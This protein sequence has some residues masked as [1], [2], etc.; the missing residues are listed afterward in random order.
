MWLTNCKVVDVESGGLMGDAAIEVESGIIRRIGAPP[1]QAENVIDLGGSYVVPGLVTCHAHLGQVY[2]FEAT[3]TT[4]SPAR[5]ALR[6]LKR[7]RDSLLAGVTTLRCVS[8]MHAVDIYLRDA[9]VAG[10]V[11]IPRLLAGGRS[12]TISGGHG[13]HFGS[14]VVADGEDAFLAAARQEIAIGADHLKIF[15]TGGIA[16]S[17]ENLDEPEMTPA[18]IRAVVT[19]ARQAKKYVVAHAAASKP[20]MEALSAGVRSFE[21]AYSLD[22]ATAQALAAA[23]VFLG[24]TLSV[25]RLPDFMR[26]TGFTEWQIAHALSVGPRHLESIRNAVEAGVT[27]VNSTDYPPGASINGTSVVVNELQ[28]MVEAGLS[29][30][31]ALRASTING[32]RLCNVDD[33]TGSICTGKSADLL[34]I[35]GD[36]SQ[37]VNAMK[38]L[39]LVMAAGRIVSSTL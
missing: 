18:E 32:A 29:P 33:I 24:P 26:E 5:T 39:R 15:I 2:P 10:W 23:D 25:T 12:L 22:K 28:L 17:V 16:E 31:E 30:F 27:L 13:S 37:D 1:R 3:D 9:A 38:G 19:A 7:A 6:A 35:D 21:H 34:V 14:S 36:P 20:I 8:E 11:E 4:E